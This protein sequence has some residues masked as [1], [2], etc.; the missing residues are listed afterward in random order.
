MMDANNFRANIARE[1]GREDE[2]PVGRLPSTTR[3]HLHKSV[4]VTL[5][6]GRYLGRV[7]GIGRASERIRPPGRRAS[8]SS[9]SST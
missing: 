1:G 9:S 8:T 3:R 7:G 4:T 6:W 2:T 5:Y